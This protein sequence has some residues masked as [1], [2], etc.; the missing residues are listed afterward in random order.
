[1]HT[2]RYQGH[3]LG[4]KTPFLVRRYEQGVK[5]TGI[6]YMHRISD[7][8][9]TGTSRR[10]FR[11]FRELCGE[12]AFQNILIVTNMG[13]DDDL[14]ACSDKER[15]LA[16]DDK[17]YKP[18]LDG[19]ARMVRHDGTPASAKAIVGQLI[20]KGEVTLIGQR[21]IVDEHKDFSG[22]AVGKELTRVLK[23]QAEEYDIE[24]R[25][26]RAGLEDSTRDR[27][28]RQ[29]R[30][31]QDDLE[32]K[33]DEIESIRS[34]LENMEQIFRTEKVRLLAIIAAMEAEKSVHVEHIRVL[35]EKQK[36]RLEHEKEE[37]LLFQQQIFSAMQKSSSWMAEA[38]LVVQRGGPSTAA[39]EK[40]FVFGEELQRERTRRQVE[41]ALWWGQ[42]L[43][44]VRK[45]A[46]ESFIQAYEA[47]VCT[48]LATRKAR[49]AKRLCK[50]TK[51]LERLQAEVDRQKEEIE[52]LVKRKGETEEEELRRERERRVGLEQA[53]KSGA[54]E[55]SVRIHTGIWICHTLAAI[56]TVVLIIWS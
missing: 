11:L 10:N 26:L 40:R 2:S 48:I 34:R 37:R 44:Q 23:E 38:P 21:E 50:A 17:Y 31:G 46:A 16:T 28:E 30:V 5:L 35:E 24:L 51:A 19:G 27:D 22:T 7:T 36:A 41:Q 15:Q 53:R 1:M 56:M 43:L 20:G 25:E 12:D 49:M 6:I 4:P 54:L 55:S 18:M 14:E 3:E 33:R 9:M 42:T 29:R 52:R 45:W 13:R 39:D 8:R 47:L 32:K